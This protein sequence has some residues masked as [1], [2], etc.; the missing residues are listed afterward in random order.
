MADDPQVLRIMAQLTDVVEH[1][2]KQT[3]VNVTDNLIATTPI[4][5]G[6]AVTNW[7]PTTGDPVANVA[8]FRDP[9]GINTGPQ[10]IGLREISMNYKIS[11]GAVYITNKVRYIGDLNNGT[12]TQEPRGFVQRAIFKGIKDL[13][14][15]ISL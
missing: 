7:I 13:A 4:D 3:A 1:V 9:S 11:K 8:G 2:V 6:F 10:E 15:T 5:T 12:S 14:G